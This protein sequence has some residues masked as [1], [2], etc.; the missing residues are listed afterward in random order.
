MMPA[1]G[2]RPWQPKTSPPRASGG[3]STVRIAL[4]AGPEMS[5]SIM[6]A[7]ALASGSPVSPDWPPKETVK[8]TPRTR[9]VTTTPRTRAKRSLFAAMREKRMRG[10]TTSTSATL[11]ARAH[12]AKATTRASQ[13]RGPSPL[14]SSTPSPK[15]RMAASVTTAP[16]MKLASFAHRTAWPETG[17]AT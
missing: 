15:G 11:T 14:P 4:A 2:N 13:A 10:R 16:A 5:P 9:S 8:T 7:T 17:S 12:N 3:H 6:A 1:S